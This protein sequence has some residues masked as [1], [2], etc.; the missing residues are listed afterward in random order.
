MFSRT[1][2]NANNEVFIEKVPETWSNGKLE[3]E[4]S[5]LLTLA[6]SAE[7]EGLEGINHNGNIILFTDLDVLHLQYK[8]LGITYALAHMERK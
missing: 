5:K 6:N 7:A 8:F 4:L 2:L 1:V 3:A